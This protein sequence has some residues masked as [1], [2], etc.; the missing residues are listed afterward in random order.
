MKTI[1][2]LGIFVFLVIAAIQQSAIGRDLICKID[3]ISSTE[4]GIEIH[5]NG[6]VNLNGTVIDRA[7]G[8][9]KFSVKTPSSAPSNGAVKSILLKEDSVAYIANGFT[10]SCILRYVNNEGRVGINIEEMSHVP[11]KPPM[12]NSQFIEA[13]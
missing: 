2:I 13:N 11:N 4:N 8:A 3:Q 1:N 6:N 7:A 9:S 10:D 12:L 5:F